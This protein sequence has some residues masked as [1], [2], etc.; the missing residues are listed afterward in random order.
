MGTLSD[1]FREKIQTLRSEGYK[2]EVIWGCEFKELQKRP[3]YL[4]VNK[5][6]VLTDQL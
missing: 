5:V 1:Q 6:E 2:V 3:D 4:D